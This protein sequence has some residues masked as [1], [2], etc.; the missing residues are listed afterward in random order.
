MIPVIRTLIAIRTLIR[1]FVDI[2]VEIYRPDTTLARNRFEVSLDMVKALFITL[3]AV[4][5][6]VGYQVVRLW[7]RRAEGGD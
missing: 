4:V 3:L 1:T 2:I 6:T 7:A 5:L